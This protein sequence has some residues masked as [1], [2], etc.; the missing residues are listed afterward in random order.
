MV[1]D[2]LFSTYFIDCIAADRITG[3]KSRMSFSSLLM[4]GDV[5]K[6][7]MIGAVFIPVNALWRS[8]L[9]PVELSKWLMFGLEK[10]MTRGQF[11]AHTLEDD[12]MVRYE[13]STI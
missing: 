13:P 7:A 8:L 11:N 10:C 4:I 3:K 6:S 1:C 5:R 9:I 12:I 2:S